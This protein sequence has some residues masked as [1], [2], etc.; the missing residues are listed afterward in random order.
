MFLRAYT[1]TT[2]EHADL[3]KRAS[4][5]M[6]LVRWFEGRDDFKAGQVSSRVKVSLAG[7]KLEVAVDPR[8]SGFWEPCAEV[9]PCLLVLVA[10][11]AR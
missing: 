2:M 4:G 8:N 7:T 3:L 5:C 1:R 11:R 9:W 6:S 10:V